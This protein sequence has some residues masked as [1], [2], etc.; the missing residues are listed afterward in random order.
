[1]KKKKVLFLLSVDTE[2]EFD[3]NGDFPQCECSVGNIQLL[4]KFHKF[5]EAVGIRPTYL[6]DYPVVATPSSAE[7]LRQIAATPSAEIG[8]HLHPWCNPPFKGGNSERESHV[9]NLPTALVEEKLSCLVRAIEEHI[10]ITPKVFRT[11]RWGIN[12]PVLKVVAAAGFDVDTSIYPF[13]E[14]EYFSCQHAC[15]QAYWP[16]FENPDVPGNQRVIFEIPVTAGFNRPHFKFWAKVHNL[17]LSWPLK[18]F[19]L[20]GV[21]WQTKVL[22]KLYLSPQRMK[23]KLRFIVELAPSSNT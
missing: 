17:L 20:V 10:G 9:I 2:E 8:A 23:T 22:R 6:V 12:S 21:A 14:N 7:V 1:M 16:A 13:Y 5:C 19:H 3:W 18:P 4:P 15:N 11:G